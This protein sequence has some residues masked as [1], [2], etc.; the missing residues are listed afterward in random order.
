MNRNNAERI[1]A[2]HPEQIIDGPRIGRI[3]DIDPTGTVRVDY[4]GNIRGP[5]SAKVAESVKERLEKRSGLEIIEIL[6]LFENG[7]PAKPVIF[8]MVA[9]RIAAAGTDIAEDEQTAPG[10]EISIDGQSI[11]FNAKD[12][13]VLRCGKASITLTKAGK[14]VI[15]GAYLLNR[16]SGVNRIKGGSVQIN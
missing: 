11:N 12:Q 10:Q 7:D 13:I 3:V 4:N 8:D 14:I 2:I 1:Q 9:E 15:R 6:L 5:L 16:S